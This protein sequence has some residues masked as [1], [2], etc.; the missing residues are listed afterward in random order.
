MIQ[1]NKKRPRKKG[2]NR[3][4]SSFFS[5][6]RLFAFAV[7]FLVLAVSVCAVGYVIFFRTVFAQEILPALRSAIVFEEPNPPVHKEP[8]DPQEPTREPIV[9]PVAEN[10]TVKKPDL[11]MVAI[12]IDD[13]GYDEAMGEQLLNLP[14]E[15]TYSF[16]PFAPHTRKL[17]NLAYLK[18]KTIFLHLPLQPKG[19]NYNPGPG[20]LYL[21]DPPEMQR[22]KFVKCLLEVPH[23]TG[24]NTHMGSIFTEDEPAMANLID[25]MKGRSLVFIDSFTTS[26]SV[27]LKVARAAEIKS[28]RRNVFL[29][30]TL[31]E[32][33]ICLQLEKLVHIAERQGWAIGIAHP[34][35][36]TVG[37]IALCGEKYRTRVEYVGVQ[38]V[39]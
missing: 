4:N 3:K 14:F 8:I 30:N 20:A 18:G 16:L 17:E 25:E 19:S 24:V 29:D 23:A 21:H 27:A 5:L 28:A 12:I 13:M 9:E 33:K 32:Q 39:L 1:K 31:D 7:L 22:A 34:H 11:P 26:G 2:R 38:A 36:V 37:A 35:R 10:V 6:K 15:L